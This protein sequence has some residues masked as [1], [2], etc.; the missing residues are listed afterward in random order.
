MNIYELKDALNKINEQAKKICRTT[1]YETSGELSSIDFDPKDPEQA[2][3][4]DELYSAVHKLDQVSWGL[5][6]LNRPIRCEG[7]LTLNNNDRYEL[8][9]IELTCG[10][11]IEIMYYDNYYERHTWIASSIEHNGKDYYFVA[12]PD[13]ELDGAKARLRK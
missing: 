2:F 8:C 10:C 3:L 12:K 6:Y 13:L 11:G 4:F 1:G 9:G 7:T 5:D